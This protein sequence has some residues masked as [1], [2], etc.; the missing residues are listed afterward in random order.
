MS[1][2]LVRKCFE[3]RIAAWAAALVVPLPIAYQNAAFSVPTDWRYGRCYV[4]PGQTD[5]VDLEGKHREYVGIFQITLSL[6][7]GKG[8]KES[9]DLADSLDTTFT[10]GLPMVQD[11]FRV[12]I[13]SPMSPAQPLDDPDALVIPVSARYRAEKFLP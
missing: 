3:T 4:L 1:Q 10:T 5:S 6:P 9:M 13:V 2:V 7:I 8:L 12:W 11:G